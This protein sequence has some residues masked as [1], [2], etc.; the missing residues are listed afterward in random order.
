MRSQAFTFKCTSE[1]RKIIRT[2]AERLQRTESDAVR[3]VVKQAASELQVEP[4]QARDQQPATAA[5]GSS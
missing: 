4:G 1:E 5:A 3:W 2:L